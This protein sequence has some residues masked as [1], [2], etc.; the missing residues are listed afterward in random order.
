MPDGEVPSAA[1]GL[2]RPLGAP[3]AGGVLR[4]PF[5]KPNMWLN[6]LLMRLPVLAGLV[7]DPGVPAPD[8]CESEPDPMPVKM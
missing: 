7:T 3:A 1:S 6:A 8:P 4:W 2:A 5:P